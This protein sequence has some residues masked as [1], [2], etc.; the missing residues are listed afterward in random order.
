MNDSSDEPSNDYL[1]MPRNPG[2][3]TNNRSANEGEGPSD[4]RL[5]ELQEGIGI[6]DAD[7]GQAGNVVLNI[8]SERSPHNI[9]FD[10]TK[11]VPPSAK[12]EAV[13]EDFNASLSMD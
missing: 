3:K 10:R 6:V 7:L 4:W 1:A 13:V 12:R 11:E 9:D 2:S 8:N 5:S